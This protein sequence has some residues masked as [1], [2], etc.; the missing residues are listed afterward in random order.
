MV[1]V[2]DPTVGTEPVRTLSN[3]ESV[4]LSLSDHPLNISLPR[5]D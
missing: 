3:V 5:A 1:R 4:T 2:Y